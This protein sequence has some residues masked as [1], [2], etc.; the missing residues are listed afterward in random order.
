MS[1]VAVASCAPRE[2]SSA[3]FGARSTYCA[4]TLPT[5]FQGRFWMRPT[6]ALFGVKLEVARDGGSDAGRIDGDIEARDR[7][8]KRCR[9]AQVD[10]LD[11]AGDLRLGRL[12]ELEFVE[13]VAGHA[14][15]LVG[16]EQAV[17]RTA[18]SSGLGAV[19]SWWPACTPTAVVSSAKPQIDRR[20]LDFDAALLLL[21]GEG[22]PDA[23]GTR[24]DRIGESDLVVLVVGV[25]P[26]VADRRR[27]R[28]RV[29][30]VLA[31]AGHLVLA[32][33]DAG[34]V[35]FA[36]GTGNARR[37]CCSARYA[38]PTKPPWKMYEPPTDAS[39]ERVD[40]FG[41]RP[42]KPPAGSRTAARRIGRDQIGIARHAV[43]ARA[44]AKGIGMEGEIAAAGVEQRAAFDGRC[45]RSRAAPRIS[46]VA[47]PGW[48]AAAA[49]L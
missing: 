8:R 21:V 17:E 42:L 19:R 47:Q 41:C 7:R 24:I 43:V 25:A 45:R 44:A 31:L 27:C 30:P 1:K 18:G 36:V 5:R 20:E 40:E 26:P 4:V 33:V 38:M 39:F 28:V 3:G 11:P 14:R 37:G 46:N 49:A 32:R 6:L 29:R 9:A 10:L 22:L 2:N 35:V 15:L 23:V 34:V 48:T 13:D 12:A 16:V